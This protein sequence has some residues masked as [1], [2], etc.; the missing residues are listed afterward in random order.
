MMPRQ[1]RQIL[2]GVLW[3]VASLVVWSAALNG[4]VFF[5]L[6]PLQPKL[7][8]SGWL[9][10]VGNTYNV[11]AIGGAV[12]IPAVVAV[13]AIRARLPWTADRASNRRGFPVEQPR[14]RHNQPMQRTGHRH[15]HVFRAGRVAA[16]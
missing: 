13:L 4:L 16:R 6:L 11:V 8:S 2:A 9:E 3:V 15:Y 10:V 7:R 1:R 5:V 12:V 14:A